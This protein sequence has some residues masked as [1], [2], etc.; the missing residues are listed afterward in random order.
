MLRTPQPY[1]HKQGYKTQNREKV[2]ARSEYKCIKN[3]TLV[4]ALR[5]Q[6]FTILQYFT[7]IGYLYLTLDW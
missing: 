1:P 6:S 3:V 5:L 7:H 4:P 2:L